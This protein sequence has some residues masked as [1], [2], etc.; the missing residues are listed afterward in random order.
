MVSEKVIVCNPS[1]LHARPASTFAQVTAKFKS[2]VIIRK[3]GKE[4]NAKSIISIL[5]ACVKHQEEMELLVNGCDEQEALVAIVG[6][7]KSGLG[8]TVTT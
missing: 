6:A 4:Y 1:G 3:D 8:E 5:K 2:T 7:V